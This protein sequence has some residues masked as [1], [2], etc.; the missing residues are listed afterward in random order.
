MDR[1]SIDKQ[2]KECG[3]KFL[4]WIGKDY[5]AGLSYNEGGELVYGDD[6]GLGKRILVL[7][8]RH[9]GAEDFESNFTRDV[10]NDFLSNK[11]R[12]RWMNFFVKFERS[13]ACNFTKKE[14]S[15]KIWNHLAFYNYIQRSFGPATKLPNPEDYTKA[16]NCF[17]N[18]LKVIKPSLVIVL[19]ERLYQYLPSSY[20]PLGFVGSEGVTINDKEE[21]YSV[22]TWKYETPDKCCYEILPVSS[23]AIGYSWEFWGKFI[24]EVVN[25][26]G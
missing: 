20:E 11:P 5:E 13:L 21:D 24:R 6:C 9:Y 2:L 23:P 10:I 12:E 8:E 7:G 4:P 14:D 18:L 19:G 16:E 1:K 26:I 3:V 15:I 25:K 17:F 22:P